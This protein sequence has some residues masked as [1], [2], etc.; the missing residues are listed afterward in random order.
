MENLDT[1]KFVEELRFAVPD[2][3]V[4]RPDKTLLQ[5]K[6]LRPLGFLYLDFL[7]SQ[8]IGKL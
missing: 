7:S 4:S 8:L 2:T 1:D 5:R 3:K 6:I